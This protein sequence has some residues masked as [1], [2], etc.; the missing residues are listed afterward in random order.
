MK[1]LLKCIYSSSRSIF[2]SKL[3][4]DNLEI[5]IK[6]IGEINMFEK[7]EAIGKDA[8][9]LYIKGMVKTGTYYLEF[10][11]YYTKNKI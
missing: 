2:Y 9:G 10:T 3:L 5:T 11:V 6:R 4:S 7:Y 1:T 8:Q